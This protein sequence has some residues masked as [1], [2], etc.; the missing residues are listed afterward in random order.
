MRPGVRLG[1]DVGSVR[2]GVARSDR[3]GLIATPVETVVRRGGDDGT[4]R[5]AELCRELEAIEVVVGLPRSLDGKERRAASLARAYAR[6]VARLVAPVPV[7]MVDERL[8]TTAAQRHMRESGRK[9]RS[10]RS[11][12]DQVAA[13]IVLQQALDAERASG[14]APGQALDGTRSEQRPHSE[15]NPQ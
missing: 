15:G 3:E 2:V 9:A 6:T 10:Q 5:V 12:V 11:V 14:R 7:R 8:S 4:A 1:V 13:V